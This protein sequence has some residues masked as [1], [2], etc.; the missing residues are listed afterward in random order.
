MKVSIF[1]TLTYRKDIDQ[2]T[3]MLARVFAKM[4]RVLELPN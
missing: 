3:G 4:A 1:D 2:L